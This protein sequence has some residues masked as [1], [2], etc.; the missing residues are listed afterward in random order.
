ML[1]EAMLMVRGVEQAGA[2]RGKQSEGAVSTARFR[3]RS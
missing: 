3:G 2:F 1:V